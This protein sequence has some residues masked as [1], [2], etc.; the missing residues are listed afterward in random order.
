ML[1]SEIGSIENMHFKPSFGLFC[2]QGLQRVLEASHGGT[3]D[4]S[5]PFLGE[6]ADSFC[7]E[8]SSP[9]TTEALI[10]SREIVDF[11]FFSNGTAQ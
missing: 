10:G 6:I 11:I 8:T 7:G 2:R 5:Y 1:R 4:S 9:E 3:I